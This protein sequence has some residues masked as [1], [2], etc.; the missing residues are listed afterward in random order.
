MEIFTLYRDWLEKKY[1]RWELEWWEFTRDSEIGYLN[2]EQHVQR[3]GDLKHES[4]FRN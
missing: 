1:L 3:H 2:R 4:L